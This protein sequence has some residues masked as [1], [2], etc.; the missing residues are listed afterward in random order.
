MEKRRFTPFERFA[1]YVT[2]DE[3]CYLC[4]RPLDL[5]T[6]EVDHVIPESLLDSPTR[7]AEVVRLLGR[8]HSFDVN[9][10]ENWL[11]ACRGCNGRKLADIFDP[12]P[13]I[14]IQLQR[15][16]RKAEAAAQLAAEAVTRRKIAN[17]LNVLQR[18]DE[19][20]ELPADT[21]ALLKPLV[22]FQR[23]H[24]AEETAGA[25][26]RLTPLY[27]VL[28]EDGDFQTVQGPY[29]IGRKSTAA[30]RDPSWD[31]AHCGSIGAWSGARCVICGYMDED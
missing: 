15:A 28:A 11:P 25:A 29:G 22:E 17:A 5:L 24:R 9:S 31:C 3:K 21:K 1:V 12:S 16:Q 14:Q 20:G 2:H 26:V 23:A 19:S 6:M 4:N 10:Y 27:V 30:N 8:P 13:M 18:A 7:L